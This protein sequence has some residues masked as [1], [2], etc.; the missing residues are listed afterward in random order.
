PNGCRP[1]GR[2]PTQRI[3]KCTTYV[4]ICERKRPLSSTTSLLKLRGALPELRKDRQRASS[5]E[6]LRYAAG[7]LGDPSLFG[8]SMGMMQDAWSLRS[9]GCAMAALL[10][11]L[12]PPSAA[13]QEGDSTRA[14]LSDT[15]EVL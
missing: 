11:S 4:R 3:R 8:C 5:K 12:L 7:M 6:T 1:V 10:L 2:S 13:A 15:T 14:T 9:V